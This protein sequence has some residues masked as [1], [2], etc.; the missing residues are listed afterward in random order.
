[1]V[2]KIPFGVYDV[3]TEFLRTAHDEINQTVPHSDYEQH[4]RC[5]KFYCGPVCEHKGVPMFVPVSHQVKETNILKT[6]TFM[7]IKDGTKT[8]GTLNF[9]YMVPVADES[10]IED[11]SHRD[12]IGEFT[13]KNIKWCMSNEELIK[14]KAKAYYN[15]FSNGYTKCDMFKDYDDITDLCYE[16]I[17]EREKK[18]KELS[19]KKARINIAVANPSIKCDTTPKTNED[20]FSK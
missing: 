1:M 4:G 12:Y 5:R 13:Q 20:T 11:I 2:S 10:L 17:D 16:I 19:E 9:A 18:A 6:Q 7:P 15:E 8:I 3:D 14:K